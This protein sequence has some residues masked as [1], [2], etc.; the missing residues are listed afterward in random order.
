MAFVTCSDNSGSLD[1]VVVFP[2]KY[3]ELKSI[4]Q[5]G[6]NV[7]LTG[8]RGDKDSFIVNNAKLI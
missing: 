6:N 1:N 8:K 7:I 3:T 2:D 5:E 4:I